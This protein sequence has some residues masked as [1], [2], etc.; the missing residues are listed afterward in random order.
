MNISKGLFAGLMILG[1]FVAGN[2]VFAQ[3]Q[4]NV[5]QQIQQM[6]ADSPIKTPGDIVNV[7]KGIL[8][9]TYLVFFILAVYFILI[10]AFNYLT[11]GGDSEKIKK[12]TSSLLWSIVAIAIGLL[13]VG[14]AQIVKSFITPTN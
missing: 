10:A 6:A 13:S 1:L 4:Q 8:R 7:L 2:D 14:A 3:Q 5:N 12:A 11:A 9:W